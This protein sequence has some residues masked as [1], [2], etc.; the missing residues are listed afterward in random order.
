MK[1]L[2]EQIGEDKFNFILGFL[3]ATL[4]L[5]FAYF[6]ND[7]TLKIYNERPF[8]MNE[9]IYKCEWQKY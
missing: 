3:M 5:G 6:K 4:V 8:E 2:V 9:R 7:K 1:S